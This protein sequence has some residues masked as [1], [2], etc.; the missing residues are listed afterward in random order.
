MAFRE[1]DATPMST[2]SRLA[3]RLQSTRS[4]VLR[5]AFV[6]T[7]IALAVGTTGAMP[8]AATWPVATPNSRV[9][10]SYKPNHRALDLA[11]VYGANV[12]PM[13]SGRTVF[14]GWKSNC[15]GYQVWVS[16]GS[17]L[18]SAYYHLSR[19]SSYKGEP[20]TGGV[21]PIGKVGTSGCATGAHLHVEVWV[22]YP[23]RSGSHRVNP[24]NYLASGR[25]L[26]YR[27]R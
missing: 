13:R 11:A 6:A 18:Y 4:H 24:W 21:E 5:R 14:A 25:Y 2:R 26:P 20:V 8:V 1:S 27:Y 9:S 16:H 17:G 22:G 15:G 23:W 19:V 12:L 10:Q 3:E 7:A